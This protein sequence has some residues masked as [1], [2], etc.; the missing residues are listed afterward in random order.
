MPRVDVLCLPF[1]KSPTSRK[2]LGFQIEL[3][4]CCQDLQEEMLRILIT[5]SQGL[6]S[7]ERSMEIQSLLEN[8]A[9]GGTVG[10]PPHVNP[11]G[12]ETASKTC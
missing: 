2:H 6:L 9:P 11:M 1:R 12:G 8:E 10:S 4:A 5:C 3:S 7:S